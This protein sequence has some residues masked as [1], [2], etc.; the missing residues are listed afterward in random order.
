MLFSVEELQELAD[1]LEKRAAGEDS[2]ECDPEDDELL[3]HRKRRG[4]RRLPKDMQ[5][6][7]LRHELTDQDARAWGRRY[8][9]GEVL[10]VP[11]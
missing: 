9:R 4:R 2:A 3:R 1:E 8:T 11:G 7:I 10:A 6:E 5:R